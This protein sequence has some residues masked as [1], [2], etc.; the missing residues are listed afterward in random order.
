M[1]NLVLYAVSLAAPPILILLGLKFV[2]R[3][4]GTTGK[5]TCATWWI[6]VIVVAW[7]TL[8]TLAVI[9][10]AYRAGMSVP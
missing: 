5:T 10:P 3:I 8:D 6:A 2:D 9:I 7:I 1:W 4:R